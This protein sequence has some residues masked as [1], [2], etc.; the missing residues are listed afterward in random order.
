MSKF[1][2]TLHKQDEIQKRIQQLK[3]KGKF[4]EAMY[5]EKGKDKIEHLWQI[6]HLWIFL[7]RKNKLFFVVVMFLILVLTIWTIYY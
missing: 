3:D 6:N 1:K 5:L 2:L 4:E 7:W